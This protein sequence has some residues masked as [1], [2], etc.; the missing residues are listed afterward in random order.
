MMTTSMTN[1][2][3][4]RLAGLVSAALASLLA[5]PGTA[6]GETSVPT[7]TSHDRHLEVCTNQEI[8]DGGGSD[9]VTALAVM[10]DG[11]HLLVGCR[12]GAV[13]LRTPDG[14]LR[15]RRQPK[16]LDVQSVA[17]TSDGQL[18]FSLAGDTIHRWSASGEPRGSFKT[19]TNA[20]CDD[21]G[22]NTLVMVIS[23][24]Q[25]SLL[26]GHSDGSAVLWNAQ[27]M[28]LRRFEDP[29]P[30]LTSRVVRLAF[31]PT[32]NSI[33]IGH[34]DGTVRRW[35]TTGRL[36]TEIETELEAVKAL[37]ITAN[38][39]VWAAGW[40]GAG[41][42]DPLGRR[43][44]TLRGNAS[45]EHLQVLSQSTAV[46]LGGSQYGDDYLE[47]RNLQDQPL[48]N[49]RLS[50]GSVPSIPVSGPMV[51]SADGR[52]LYMAVSAWIY[53]WDLPHHGYS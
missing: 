34:E 8:R 15:F 49:L 16:L 21:E 24:N 53:R 18:L 33:A 11:K 44:A 42:W 51:V 25:G 48:L 36:L 43:Q 10:P 30:F 7:L 12:S 46:V 26:T 9:G 13:E 4:K 20:D 52:L 32:G 19:A 23:T 27:G 45:I 31:D 47:I 2:Q 17:V 6:R 39:D 1:Q 22:C 40:Y 38:G 14:Q 41:R 28:Q 3:M 50:D 35:S 5:L 29:S 37:A